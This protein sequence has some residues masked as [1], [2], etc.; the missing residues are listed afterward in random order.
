MNVKCSY[1]D[2]LRAGVVRAAAR[3]LEQRAGGLQRRH[4]EVRDLDV[5]PLVQ[6]QILRLEI[7]VAA[8]VVTRCYKLFTP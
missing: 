5:V 1:P 7:A 4:A 3:G 2:D 6:Q 8:D